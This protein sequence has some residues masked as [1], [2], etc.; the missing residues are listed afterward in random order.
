[1]SNG[2]K[3]SENAEYNTNDGEKIY[4]VIAAIKIK[5]KYLHIYWQKWLIKARKN[6][7]N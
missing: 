6:E 1:M 5:V 2:N 4:T 7:W 3:Y